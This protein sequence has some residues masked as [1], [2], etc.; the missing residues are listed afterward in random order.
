MCLIAGVNPPVYVDRFGGI[1]EI[2]DSE[3]QVIRGQAFGVL[4]PGF[5]ALTSF[6]KIFNIAPF[7]VM[8]CFLLGDY[9][10]TNI[11]PKKELRLS[12]WVQLGECIVGA[13]K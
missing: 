5:G 8:T 13:C 6:P 9:N 4:P 1:G 2:S 10:N 3:R 12:L 7:L 11:L